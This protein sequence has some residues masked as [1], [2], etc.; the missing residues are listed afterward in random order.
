MLDSYPSDP[1]V[2]L[3]QAKEIPGS[4]WPLWSQWLSQH[5]GGTRKAPAKTGN[6]KYPP[7]E[8][9]PGRYVKHRIH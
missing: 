9:A 5:A 8:P 2:W 6:A 7:L 1:D 4:W 3:E